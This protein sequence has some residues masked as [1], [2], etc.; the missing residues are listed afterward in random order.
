[1]NKG[2]CFLRGHGDS[3]PIAMITESASFRRGLKSEVR[4]LK[5]KAGPPSAEFLVG[6]RRRP[7]FS[8]FSYFKYESIGIPPFGPAGLRMAGEL[9][10]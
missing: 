6:L 10:V 3:V 8:M 1:M 7:G 4:S 2:L 9:T 5:R